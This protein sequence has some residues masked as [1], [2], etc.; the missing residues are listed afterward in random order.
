MQPPT[1]AS[2]AAPVAL[3]ASASAMARW[4]IHS[5]TSCPVAPSGLIETGAPAAS[6]TT[7][8]QVASKPMPAT[9]SAATPDDASAARQAAAAAAQI[10]A[11][12]CC[13]KSGRGR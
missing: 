11:E 1:C 6:A 4:S 7:S 13:A 10:S 3:I 2:T 9:R 5:T 8:E 12:L